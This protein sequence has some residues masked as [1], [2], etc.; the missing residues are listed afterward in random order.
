MICDDQE[1]GTGKNKTGKD[2]KSIYE[3]NIKFLPQ[4]SY[5]PLGI[6]NQPRG[7]QAILKTIFQ[8]ID[9]SKHLVTGSH[10]SSLSISQGPSI[11]TPTHI[12]TN[13]PTSGLHKLRANE[14]Q[15]DSHVLTLKK[16]QVKEKNVEEQVK[17]HTEFVHQASVRIRGEVERV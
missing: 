11:P 1:W 3:F 8:R 12:H 15:L 5:L 6:P 4:W 2:D 16:A 17:A 14:L 9:R 7:G 13:T 10:H